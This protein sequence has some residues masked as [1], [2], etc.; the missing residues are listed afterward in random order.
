MTRGR[1]FRPGT[2]HETASISSSIRQSPIEKLYIDIDQSPRATFF[3]RPPKLSRAN[4]GDRKV[5]EQ[6]ALP[7]LHFNIGPYEYEGLER[8]DVDFG[9]QLPINST[10]GPDSPRINHYTKVPF[11]TIARIEKTDADNDLPPLPDSP[12]AF[13]DAT[14]DAEKSWK[15]EYWA[16][17]FDTSNWSTTGQTCAQ[18]LVDRDAL[19]NEVCF[20]DEIK[21]T[22]TWK[23]FFRFCGNHCQLSGSRRTLVSKVNR[24]V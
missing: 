12:I 22:C 10:E 9:R 7:P 18:E 11:Y 3:I 8:A 16:A 2:M 13:A 21:K 4:G 23:R 5:P 17:K 14:D 20:D 6:P 19:I 1:G 24:T 15:E